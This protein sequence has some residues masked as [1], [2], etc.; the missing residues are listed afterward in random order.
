M[1]SATLALALLAAQPSAVRRVEGPLS[2]VPMPRI[3]FSCLNSDGFPTLRMDREGV[4]D[5]WYNQVGDP[6]VIFVVNDP[7]GTAVYEGDDH[8]G[9]YLLTINGTTGGGRGIADGLPVRI[10]LTIRQVGN[11]VTT[12]DYVIRAGAFT[13]RETMCGTMPMLPSSTSTPS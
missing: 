4:R 7:S 2:A 1:V 10:E 8:D 3:G 13:R 5:I 6:L 12:A 11:H 9:S